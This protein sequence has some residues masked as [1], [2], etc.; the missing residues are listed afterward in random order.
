MRTFRVYVPAIYSGQTPRPLVFQFHGEPG[1]SI[2]FEGFT[3][4]KNV[5]DTADFIL[6]TPDG[7]VD[8]GFPQYGPGWNTYFC[9]RTVN[10]VLFVSDMIDLLQ[11]QYNVDST[12]VYGTGFSN[13]GM[14]VYELACKL[15]NKIAAIASVAGSMINSRLETCD[16]DR[17]MPV[18]EIHGTNDPVIPYI[19]KI[20]GIDTFPNIDSILRYWV[21]QNMCTSVAE[22]VDLPNTNNSDGSTV[23]SVSYPNCTSCGAVELLKIIGIGAGHSWPGLPTSTTN[24]DIIA[25]QEIWRFFL[26][27]KLCEVST[28]SNPFQSG[29]FSIFPNPASGFLILSFHGNPTHS[30]PVSLLIADLYGKIMLQQ[31]VSFVSQNQQISLDLNPIPAGGYFLIIENESGYRMYSRFVI[32]H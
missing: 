12:R 25:D 27:H 2:G 21:V 4:F 22:M 30:K 5:A 29:A 17:A 23:I 14:M 9:C 26:K 13:G 18:L 24:Q 1:S 19:G 7:T 6:V 3:R 32:V 10:D 8:P 15:S 28:T 31:K 20:N 11:S 16:P